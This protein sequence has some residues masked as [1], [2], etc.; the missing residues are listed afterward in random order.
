MEH[1]VTL[2]QF[3]DIDWEYF[4]TVVRSPV[5]RSDSRVIRVALFGD[6]G[7]GSAGTRDAHLILSVCMTAVWTWNADALILDLTSLSYVWG[8]D[9]IAVLE[10]GR[11]PEFAHRDLATVAITSERNDAAMRSLVEAI[12]L[13]PQDVLASSKEEALN[14]VL[15]ER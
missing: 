1:R 6:Y 7:V 9:M 14:L 13:D 10:I 4:L 8:D 2:E 3:S 5:P 12:D 11:L 15:R